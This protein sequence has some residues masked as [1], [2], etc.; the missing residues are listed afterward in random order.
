MITS[1]EFPAASRTFVGSS[2]VEAL[3]GLEFRGLGVQASVFRV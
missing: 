2:S 3:K 1:P